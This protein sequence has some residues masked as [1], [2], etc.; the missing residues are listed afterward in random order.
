MTDHKARVRRLAD[1]IQIIVAEILDR[2]IKDPRLGFVTLT[3]VKVTNDLREASIFYT[4]LGDPTEQADSAA[5]LS[6]A[7]GMIRS[8]MGQALGVRF[9]PS[10]EFI[11]DAIPENAAHIDELLKQA[12]ES[13][14]RISEQAA[15][16]D[17]AGES[18]PYH[19]EQA[20]DAEPVD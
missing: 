15:Q 20:E 10:I 12:A 6:S 3:D 17:F 8:E 2:R 7:K 1:R 16:A 13:D 4:V 5:A 18:E 14:S 19:A 9:T 11:A